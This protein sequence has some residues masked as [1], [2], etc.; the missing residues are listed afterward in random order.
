M[1]GEL[2]K[3]FDRDFAIAYF[4][5]SASF[6]T[7]SYCILIRFSLSPV[8]LALS[9]DS[10]LK[11]LASLGLLSL[12]GAIILLIAN[13]GI[14]R[15]LEGYWPFG[16]GYWVNWLQ[17]RRFRRLSRESAKS[18]VDKQ[19]YEQRNE[20]FPRKLQNKRNRIKEDQANRFPNEERLILPTS[21]GNTYRAF[22][23]YP[24]VMYG[25]NAIPGWFRLLAVVPKDYRALLDAARAQVDFWVNLSFLSL[26]VIIEYYFAA[27]RANRLVFSGLF[28]GSATLHWIPLL[29]LVFSVVAYTFAR[30]AVQDWGN[31]VKSAFDMYLSDLRDKLGFARP[32]DREHGRRMWIAFNRAVLARNAELLPETHSPQEQYTVERLSTDLRRLNKDDR[33][34]FLESALRTGFDESSAPDLDVEQIIR[35][36]REQARHWL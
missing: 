24:R 28:S 26:I 30:N 11:D 25:I 35:A 12:L 27:F 1:F 10:V 17:L 15:L 21:F 13:R 18:D 9:A 36:L 33:L 8:V 20:E 3:L 7:A 4:L 29:A 6:V 22:E 23:V 5:P 2:P 31:W 19:S 14:V 16:L 34:S 32:Q